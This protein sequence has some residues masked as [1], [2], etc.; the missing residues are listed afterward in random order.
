MP[1]YHS[2]NLSQTDRPQ[3]NYPL[4]PQTPDRTKPLAPRNLIIT[5][6]YSIEKTDI[7]WDNPKIIPQNSGLNILGCNVY[8]STDGPDSYVKINDTPV[9]VL[10]HR[11]ETQ[12]QAVVSE[13]A[14][15]TIKHVL[16]PEDKWFVYAQNRPIIIPGTNGTPTTRIEDV[17]VEIDNGDGVFLEWPPFSVNGTTGEI[18]L[19]RASVYNYE[20]QQIVPPRLPYP[21]NGRVRIS[22]NYLKHHVL[23]ALSQR[24]Y[25][26]VTTVAEDPDDNTATIETPLDEISDRTAFDVE[27]IDYIW[28]EAIKR[29]RWILEQ[30]GERVKIF[31]RKWMGATCPSHETL[32]GQGY[33]DCLE[34]FPAGQEVTMSDGSRKKIEDVITGD[35]IIDHKGSIEDVYE[36]KT[37]NYNGF[38]YNINM[39]GKDPVTCTEKHPFL[40]IKKE[41][42]RCDRLNHSSTRNKCIPMTKGLCFKGYN[43]RTTD[44]TYRPSTSWVRAK[45]LKEG[46]YLLVPRIKKEKNNFSKEEM[47]LFGFYVADGCLSKNISSVK[48]RLR[49]AFGKKEMETVK[50]VKKMFKIQYGKNLEL[51]NC[52]NIYELCIHDKIIADKFLKHC[53]EYAYTK[54][55]SIEIME[56]S[57]EL[58]SYFL[59]GYILG[60]GHVSK[61]EISYGSIYYSTVSKNLSSQLELLFSKIGCTVRTHFTF[62]KDNRLNRSSSSCWIYT[63][64]VSGVSAHLIKLFGRKEIYKDVKKK[65]H[66]VLPLENY[67]CYPIKEIV[68][69]KFKGQV[70]NIEI[71]NSHTYLIN[72][73]AAHNCYG[74]NIVGGYDGPYNV[75]IAP[76]ESEKMVELNDMGLHIRYDWASWMGPWPLLNERDVIVRQ[77]NERY[78]VGPV[79]PQGSRGAI[80]QQHFSMSYVDQGDIRY[81]IPIT[82]GETSVPASYDPYREDAPTDASPA[83]NDKPEIPEERIIRGR[84]VIFENITY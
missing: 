76:P 11:D 60:D 23:T 44:C 12:E 26:K 5:S 47:F 29:N 40:I 46:D 8:R 7:R 84:T 1:V 6:P 58:I 34:C 31:I 66:R 77:N 51:F 3:Y 42:A 43:L 81:Q 2:G 49:F 70:H 64:H 9:T 50:I 75:L 52:S 72:N 37:R 13:N 16:E 82:G 41:D 32:Y 71:E 21:P 79:T 69:E 36:I 28:R 30:G 10:F 19:I 73:I 25:Y 4:R 38:L 56:C 54:K 78:V 63:S 18:E 20:L 80:Y 61:R 83:I 59:G 24:I 55:L 22:Y 35:K 62:K 33:N 14:T 15:P 39:V 68:K 57:K 27:A 48:N 74:T 65:N 17:T 53:G 67:I 45:D